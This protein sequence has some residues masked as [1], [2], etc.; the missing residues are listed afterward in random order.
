[1]LTVAGAKRLVRRYAGIPIRIRVEAESDEPPDATGMVIDVPTGSGATMTGEMVGTL[2]VFSDSGAGTPFDADK[3][4]MLADLADAAARE[5]EMIFAIRQRNRES[6]MRKSIN[7]LL[8][9]SL[10]PSN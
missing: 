10:S 8:C 1:M 5:I 6:A 3:L 7:D 9:P 2:C 4:V